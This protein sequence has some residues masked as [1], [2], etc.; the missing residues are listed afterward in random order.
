MKSLDDYDPNRCPVCGFD[1]EEDKHN[2]GHCDERGQF[3]CW[4]HDEDDLYDELFWIEI[5]G[6]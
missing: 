3:W 5:K 1:I 2:N 6:G 4:Q